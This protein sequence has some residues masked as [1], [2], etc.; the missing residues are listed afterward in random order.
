MIAAIAPIVIATFSFLLRLNNLGSIKTLIFDEV[1]YVD[2]A[3]DFLK[4]GVEVTGAQ[5]EFVVHPPLGKWM[6]AAGIKVFGDDS[7]GWRFTTALVGSLMILLIALIAHKL[8]RNSL[9]TGLASALMAIDGLALVHSRTALL[10]NF[11]TFFILIATYFF[12]SRNYWLTGFALGL[13]LATK[14]SAL[15]FILVFGGIALYRAFTHNTGRNLIRP[16]VERFSQ[17]GLIPIAVYIASWSGWFSS[18]R[19]WARDLSSNTFSSFINYHQQML[20]FHTGLTEKHNYEAN[21]WSWLIMGRPTSFY[22]KSPQG[23][24][25]ESCSQEVLAL[26]T[27]LLW[28]LGT[29]ALAF[30]IGMWIRG[31]V[32]KQVDPAKTIIIAGMSAG[33]LPWFLFQ[34]RTVFNFYSIVFEPFL[35]LALVFAAR[36]ILST[37]KKSGEVVLGAVFILIFLNF[38]YFLPIYLGDVIT[39]EAWQNRMWFPSWI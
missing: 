11:L 22:Y 16:T 34:Q 12:V 14:W 25:A 39:Y 37:F 20:N 3:R 36:M 32:Q 35:I 8:F 5:S 33:Y 10:D 7:F 29:I 15:Y 18:N 13:A 23:C 30:V 4:Y 24:G 31:L 6:I 19:G 21:P 17:F 9:L 28:W 27:P 26:G 2:G 38:V 1:Y